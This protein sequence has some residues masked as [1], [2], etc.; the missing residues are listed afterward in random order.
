MN[1]KFSTLLVS[2]LLTGSVFSVSAQLDT[3]AMPRSAAVVGSAV[4]ALAE[5]GES[6][7]YKSN[8]YYQLGIAT[9][10][11]VL[12]MTW[13]SSAEK[14]EL[15]LQD[16][17][18]EDVPLDNTLW[19][20]S[21][22][23][24]KTSGTVNYIFV[25][26]VTLLPLQVAAPGLDPITGNPIVNGAATVEG[27]VTNWIWAPNVKDLKANQLVAT[28]NTTYK[29]ALVTDASKDNVFVEQ[30]DANGAISSEV[31]ELT[32]YEAGRVVLTA[33]QINTKL[34]MVTEANKPLDIV[35]TPDVI[36]PDKEAAKNIITET[37]WLARGTK[38]DFT[39]AGNGDYSLKKKDNSFYVKDFSNLD[40][41][42]K[43]YS[44]DV[45][46]NF[47]QLVSYKDSI[48]KWNGANIDPAVLMVDTA[49]YDNAVNDAY[50]LKLVL[51][52]LTKNKNNYDA[53]T[54]NVLDGYNGSTAAYKTF[55]EQTLFQFIYEPTYDRVLVQAKQVTRVKKENLSENYEKQGKAYI[56]FALIEAETAAKNDGFVVA[57]AATLTATAGNAVIADN[58]V[59]L[60]YLSP[61]HSELT[62][63]VPDANDLAAG[64]AGFGGALTTITL[65]GTKGLLGEWSYADITAGYYYIQNAK[66]EVSPL[67]PVGGWAY[68]DLTATSASSTRADGNIVYSAEQFKT[69]PSA[70]WYIKGEGGFYTIYNRESGKPWS[71]NYWYAVKDANGVNVPNVYT[72]YGTFSGNGISSVGKD[73]I[74]LTQVPADVYKEKLNGYLNIS[75]EVAKADTSVFTFKYVT[76]LEGVNLGMIMKSDSSL[77]MANG[78]ALN[79]K[80]ERVSGSNVKYGFEEQQNMDNKLERADYFIYLDEVSSNSSEWT[81]YRERKY[82]I[83]EGGKYRLANIPVWYNAQNGTTSAVDSRRAKF[84]V[85]EIG[86]ADKNYVLV[87]VND[88]ISAPSTGQGTAV[89]GV[90]MAMDQTSLLMRANGL[91]SVA[92][93]VYTNS[94]LNLVKA[95]AGNYV[96]TIAYGDTV[97][98]FSNDYPEVVMYENGNM[99]AMSSLEAGR[100]YNTALFVDTAY[101]RDNTARPQYMF[102]LRPVFD[103]NCNF[104]NHAH[105]A[106]EG[107]YLVH[108]QDSVAQDVNKYTWDNKKFARLGFVPARHEG[109]TLLIKN[110]MFTGNNAQISS[111]KAA[112]YAGK[113][114]I[115][116]A[117][118]AKDQ[119]CTFALRYTDTNRDAFYLETLYKKGT[120]ADKYNNEVADTKGWVR[121]H[122]GVPVVVNDLSQAGKFN[123]ETVSEN[124]TANDEV[125]V[126]SVV[127]TA[128][129][130]KIIIRGAEGKK[131]V[132]N[133]VLGQN[134][135]N[136]VITSSE[137][138]IAAPAGIVVVA[139]E[140][141]AAVKAIV[142]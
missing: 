42:D 5:V 54:K 35:F 40:A 3:P 1:R 17:A 105:H 23:W 77:A 125:S 21:A 89:N 65:K 33:E 62:V 46:D 86:E 11:K 82:V 8:G 72:N 31:L 28:V 66:T 129:E 119:Y 39:D 100:E 61:N 98:V 135:A 138:T 27:A 137:A 44:E 15:T 107:D 51:R 122:N 41:A 10:T 64:A 24:D 109:D 115:D 97:K 50:D 118:N 90:R 55:Q 91:P 69:M 128:A 70:Q 142:K 16:I 22:T 92:E 38:F 139:V 130:G 76:P 136:T 56:P 80:L 47:V 34:A 58:M 81:G 60:V 141:E 106:V 121:W 6:G 37:A 20:V 57:T 45:A 9:T 124:P 132:I 94:L 14:Y 71:T 30:Y 116:L 87:D 19:Q 83:L 95:A 126:Y 99:L 108:M 29:V 74:R 102:V 96:S 127:V 79:F 93:N 114:T 131:V 2:A 123:F 110:S 112:T 13:S 49:Y 84:F 133:N 78:E 117:N 4:T 73:T 68:Q 104:P 12:A 52:Q 63:N 75:Q 101:V 140:G 88:R 113:D 134:I 59:K 67:I 32:A 18:G 25:N 48:A 111:D 7:Q 103:P 43:D 26:K 53:T 36:N 120:P 85:K